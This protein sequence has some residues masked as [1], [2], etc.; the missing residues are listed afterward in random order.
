MG[1]FGLGLGLGLGYEHLNLN[2]LGG[3]GISENFSNLS[4]GGGVG[5]RLKNY[6]FEASLGYTVRPTS[7]AQNKQCVNG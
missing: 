2:D 7:K 6:K 4:P 1:L 3:C 5:K